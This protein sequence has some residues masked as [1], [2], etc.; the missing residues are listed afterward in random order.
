MANFLFVREVLIFY[1]V[2]IIFILIFNNI[3]CKKEKSRYI[4]DSRDFIIKDL[5]SYNFSIVSRTIS[6]NSVILFIISSIKHRCERNKIKQT[7]LK[8]CERI[9]CYYYFVIATNSKKYI[10]NDIWN[11]HII[12]IDIIDSYYNL[13]IFTANIYKYF[14]LYNISSNYIIKIDD[15]IFPNIP[16]IIL[17]INIFMDKNKIAGYYYSQMK[18]QRKRNSSVYLSKEMYPHD[19][20][21][22]FVAGGFVI[23]HSQY[24]LKFYY[25]L[26]KEKRILYREDMHMATIYKKLNISFQPLNRY[27]HRRNKKLSYS[28]KVND[29]CWHGFK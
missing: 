24:I 23:T 4:Q 19:I 5:Y 20:F 8:V 21:P 28:L 10:K 9:S 11:N 27:Y 2:F 3:Q 13:T 14:V 6:F 15:D 1:N 18:V 22:H 25:E 12:G 29:I 7:W 26:S 16:L 17:F